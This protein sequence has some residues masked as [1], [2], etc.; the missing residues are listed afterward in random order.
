MRNLSLVQTLHTTTPA[1]SNISAITLDL[2]EN[3]SY[4][5]TERQ[6]PDADV[7][8]EVRKVEADGQL[9][10]VRMDLGAYTR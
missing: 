2:D 8:V 6:T 9:T 3:V 1:G 4:V 10:E 5:A 7:V